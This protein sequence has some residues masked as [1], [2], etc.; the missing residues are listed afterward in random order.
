MMTVASHHGLQMYVCVQ[1]DKNN[2]IIR[3]EN[4]LE[5]KKIIYVFKFWSLKLGFVYN[6]K[7]VLVLHEATV[8]T[9]L[10]MVLKKENS[11]TFS[12]GGCEILEEELKIKERD[13][14]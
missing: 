9:R 6:L 3:L 5:R 7:N 14:K 1:L 13:N 12:L 8:M 4:G 10:K 11:I 2:L